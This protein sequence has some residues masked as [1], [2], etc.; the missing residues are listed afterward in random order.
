MPQFIYMAKLS[1]E[2]IKHIAKLSRLELTDEEVSLYSDQLSSVLEY[3]EQLNEINTENVD[4]L[5]SMTGLSN[6]F[7]DD[8][9]S[10]SNI[11]YVDSEKNA[12]E[13][14]AGHFVVPG[15]FD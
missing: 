5:A 8:K 9:V 11:G 13:F 1:E 2:Q 15:V 4:P 7:R 6:I 14:E 12:P 3:V 10:E